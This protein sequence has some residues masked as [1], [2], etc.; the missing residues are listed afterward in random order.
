MPILTMI[1]SNQHQSRMSALVY[2]IYVQICR[3]DSLVNSYSF[4]ALSKPI[5]PSI[6]LCPFHAFKALLRPGH[7]HLK[8]Y[9]SFHW[10]CGIARGDA[11]KLFCVKF[12][13]GELWLAD[14]APWPVAICLVSADL[15]GIGELESKMKETIVAYYPCCTLHFMSFTVSKHFSFTA[16]PQSLYWMKRCTIPIDN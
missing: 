11:V 12:D 9:N 14:L 15:W 2:H 5:H 13:F 8:S 7:Q 6:F 1:C 4:G 16:F 3:I 10:D